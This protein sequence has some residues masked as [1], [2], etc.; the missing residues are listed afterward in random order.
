[1]GYEKIL[2]QLGD[3]DE[4]NVD[5][6]AGTDANPIRINNPAEIFNY[7]RTGDKSN[8]CIGY[9]QERFDD[10]VEE[11]V[12]I[13]H[14]TPNTVY[15]LKDYKDHDTSQF[16]LDSFKWNEF[17]NTTGDFYGGISFMLCRAWRI[18]I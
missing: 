13:G 3:M 1:M 11:I 12:F 10:K 6:I 8:D 7:L 9:T 15:A 5:L 4:R 18:H 14:G 2:F 16:V 17:E